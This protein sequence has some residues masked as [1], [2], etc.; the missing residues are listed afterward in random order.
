MDKE[1]KE[2]KED[3]AYDAGY[4]WVYESAFQP[5]NYT[6]PNYIT[7]FPGFENYWKKGVESAKKNIDKKSRIM[8]GRKT[9]KRITKKSKRRKSYKR[10]R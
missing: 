2:D 9:R 6:G 1:D 10:R 8:G 7:N 4:N 5:M 3:E